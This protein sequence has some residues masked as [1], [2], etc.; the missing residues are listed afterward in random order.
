MKN[1]TI[2]EA[3]VR[4]LEEKRLQIR[5][6]S[7]AAYLLTVRNHILPAFGEKRDLSEKDVQL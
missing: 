5:E 2:S 6:S 1:K 7:Y 4:W 3:S